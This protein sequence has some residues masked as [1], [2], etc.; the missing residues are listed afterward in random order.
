M[1]ARSQPTNEHNWYRI[2]N[3]PEHREVWTK[4]SDDFGEYLECKLTRRGNCWFTHPTS[5]V[6][7]DY[8]PT[9][10]SPT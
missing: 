4:I 2:E 1:T 5:G 8:S 6:D 7:V 3:A 10:W 9:H